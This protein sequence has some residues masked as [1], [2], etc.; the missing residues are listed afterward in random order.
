MNAIPVEHRWKYLL[1]KK[2]D[3]IIGSLQGKVYIQHIYD[4]TI[5]LRVS[6][7]CWAQ[8]LLM[9]SAM[10]KK[11][12]NKVINNDTIKEIRFSYQSFIKPPSK[13]EI[14]THFFD[15]SQAQLSFLCSTMT[16][17]EQKALK[18]IDEPELQGIFK[19]FYKMCKQRQL[20]KKTTP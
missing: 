16:E 6:H 2:W 12:I 8:E 7:P 11:K 20:T 5:L 15:F 13:E 18:N 9:M 4:Q 1:F 14:R 10:L 19:G 3:S 17:S